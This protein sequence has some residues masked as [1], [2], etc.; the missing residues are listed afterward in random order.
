MK[1]PTKE[2]R[3]FILRN[4]RNVINKIL[5]RQKLES[6]MTAWVASQVGRGGSYGSWLL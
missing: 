1:C 3:T 4:S 5:V 2:I 6:C